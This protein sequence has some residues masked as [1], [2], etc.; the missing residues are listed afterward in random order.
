MFSVFLLS[1]ILARAHASIDDFIS[2]SSLMKLTTPVDSELPSLA[3]QYLKRAHVLL[4][5]PI[6]M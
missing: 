6:Y 2:S 3:L 4:T 5:F 1:A